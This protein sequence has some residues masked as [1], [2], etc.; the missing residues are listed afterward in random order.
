MCLA[1]KIIV[2]NF[3]NEIILGAASGCKRKPFN[4]EIHSSFLVGGTAK[5]SIKAHPV[6]VRFFGLN[7]RLCANKLTN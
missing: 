2:S 1:D 7:Q 5:N 4:T 6:R 3:A